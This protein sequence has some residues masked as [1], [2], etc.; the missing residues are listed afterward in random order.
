MKELYL[1]ETYQFYF[2]RL[3]LSAFGP[4]GEAMAAKKKKDDATA[5]EKVKE[6]AKKKQE[7]KKKSPSLTGSDVAAFA[8]TRREANYHAV[9]CPGKNT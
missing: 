2:L 7:A 8:H 6:A 3:L 9:H 4:E 1:I 5:A